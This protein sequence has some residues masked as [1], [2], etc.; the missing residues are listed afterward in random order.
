MTAAERQDL[1]MAVLRKQHCV[2]RNELATACGCNERTIRRDIDALS[3]SGFPVEAVPGNGGGVRLAEWYQPHR[4]TLGP[5]QKDVLRR[6][7]ASAQPDDRA[8]LGSIIDQ[9]GP[10]R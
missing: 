5:E 6:F 2:V 1:I 10:R 4:T 9:F 3:A 7:M 8:I